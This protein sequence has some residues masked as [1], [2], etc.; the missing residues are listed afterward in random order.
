MKRAATGLLLGVLA[1]WLTAHVW[2]HEMT[3]KGT[4][5]A[6]EAARIQIKTGE[7]KAGEQPGWFP[8]DDKTIVKRGS[9]T[10]T[11]ADAKITVE[12]RV[13]AIVDH[14]TKGPMRTKELR[15]AAQ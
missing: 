11:L 6:I 1:V 2:A 3:V 9:K 14:P 10:V 4:V 13:V 15:L 5:T 8:I 12:E 7:E